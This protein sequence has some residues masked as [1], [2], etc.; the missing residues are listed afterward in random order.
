MSK[1]VKNELDIR[2]VLL[3]FWVALFSAGVGIGGGTI[4]VSIFIS[5]FGFDFKK[6]ASTSLAA[7]IPISM[8]GAMSH[9]IFLSHT[10]PLRYYFMFIPACMLGAIVGGKI[11]HKQKSTWFKFAFSV[12]L[13]IVSLRMLKV[14]DLSSLA[15]GGLQTILHI[16]ELPFI[17]FFGIIIGITAT[18]LGLGCG[19]LI[20]PFYVII[21][22]LNIHE[23]IRLSLTTMFFL[24]FRRR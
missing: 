16:N 12:F 24:H 11:F 20:V 21:I 19:L 5:V 2:L 8:I 15:Y 3:G 9:F 13:L 1:F 17:I 14:I 7:I 22:G 6:A 23:A 10:P 4:F 18:F